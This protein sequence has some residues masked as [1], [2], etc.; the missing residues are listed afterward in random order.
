MPCCGAAAQTESSA[1]GT[2]EIAWQ[3]WVTPN[4]TL[5]FW[6]EVA[7]A[8]VAEHPDVTI[9]LIEAN[10]AVTPSATD[11]IKTR[12]AAGDVPDL[13]SNISIKDFADAGIL[14]ALPDDDPTCSGS[15]T[16][17]PLV[18][19]GRC[20]DCPPRCSRRGLLFYNK[21]LFAEAG[22]DRYA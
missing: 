10:A 5:E 12:I 6:Q 19:R 16:W 4:L 13:M 22:S 2:K 18:T 17:T 3:V 15:A 14:W 9:E 7:D 11:F 20:T 1:D 8:F 21:A